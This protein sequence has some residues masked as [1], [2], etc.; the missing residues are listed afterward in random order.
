[1]FYLAN[2]YFDMKEFANARKWYER[3]IEMGGWDQ[4]VY[5]SM[6]RVA[7]SMAQL[8][9][10]WPDVQNAYLQAWEFRPSRAEPLDAM[11]RRYRQ[12]KRYLLGHMFAQRAA[13]IPFPEKDNLFVT[14]S[15]YAWR[16]LDEQAVCANWIGKKAEAFTLCRRLLATPDLPDSE[17]KRITRNRDFSVPAMVEA[18]SSY[19]DALVGSLVAGQRNGEITVSL[20]AGPDRVTTE[21]TLNSFLHCCSDVS[22]VGRFLV[23]D[24]GLSAGDRA[25]LVDRYSFLEFVDYGRDDG[26]GAQLAQLR[27][28][29]HERFWL[30]VGH[31]WRFFAPD[32][33]ITRLTAV[34][35]AEAHVFQ[36]G[37]NFADAVALIGATALEQEVRRTPDAGRY[38]QAHVIA[39]GPAMF[40]TVRLD[41]AGGLVSTDP[42]PI[43]T[44][45]QRAAA[46][47]L[48]TA[49][50]DEVLCIAST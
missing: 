47:G 9:E 40:D 39:S 29:I 33:L 2:S 21:Q 6:F 31:G 23:L 8:D 36:V 37:I 41:R 15:V 10:P 14:V 3:R 49:S 11:A 35:D 24:A 48:H 18:A 16:A 44:L 45:G 38:V 34:L 20:I 26:T 50:L 12:E 46:A 22:R 27:E 7:E 4:E 13:Q 25:M 30:H 1:V 5:Y 19:P 17:R 32:N 28:Q 43:G 42:D